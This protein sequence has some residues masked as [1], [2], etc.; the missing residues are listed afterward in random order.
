VVRRVTSRAERPRPQPHPL[1]GLGL[2]PNPSRTGASGA[3]QGD[4]PTGH[5]SVNVVVHSD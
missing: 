3:V 2:L 5:S 1:V 4:R